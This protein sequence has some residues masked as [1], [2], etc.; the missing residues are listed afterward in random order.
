MFGFIINW[1]RA[2]QRAT[3]VSL[4]WPEC[5]RQTHGDTEV[6]KAVFALHAFRDPAWRALGEQAIIEF[7][8]G[9][10]P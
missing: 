3:D 7:V 8:T 6:A 1:W 2:Q 9:L 10:Q 4:L 5:V